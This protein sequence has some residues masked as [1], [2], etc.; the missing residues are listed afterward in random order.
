MIYEHDAEAAPDAD[1]GPGRLADLVPGNRG[2]LLDPRRTPVTIAGTVLETGVFSVRV[3]AFEDAGAVW[4]VPF[5][6]VARFQFARG[7]ALRD[8]VAQLEAVVARLDRPLVIDA[9]S[10]ASSFARLLEEREAAR[11]W[12]I[13]LPALGS[14]AEERMGEPALF[15]ALGA[16]MDD[17]GV[18]ELE[19]AFAERFVSNPWSGELVKGHAIVLAELGL[20]P[21]RGKVVRDPAL[22]DGA[23]SR[24]RRAAHLL[25][26]MAF[27]QE[28]FG[29]RSVTVYR[30]SREPETASFVSASFSRAVAAENVAG[31]AGTVRAWVVPAE[32][33]FMT[34]METEAMNRRYRE[35]EAVLLGH[36]FA[37]AAPRA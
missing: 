14:Y 36:G 26:R 30:G 27:V 25:A 5:E 24:E 12:V 10:P 20:C 11:E 35:A 33:L 34:F 19:R 6:D 8:D 3:D 9:R 17:R 1:F 15:R 28:L 18:G 22:F 4:E 13:P 7:G 21:F 32:R 2:R 37:P 29:G 31:R 23:W 16:F